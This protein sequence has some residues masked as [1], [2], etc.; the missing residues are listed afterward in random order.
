MFCYQTAEKVL[1]SM[2]GNNMKLLYHVCLLLLS[3]VHS[4]H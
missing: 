1:I 2:F 4:A 3:L